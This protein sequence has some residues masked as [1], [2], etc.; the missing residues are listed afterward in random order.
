M[1][2][3]GFT[4]NDFIKHNLLVSPRPLHCMAT[5]PTCLYNTFKWWAWEE[6]NLRPLHYQ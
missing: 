1:G 4:E 6:S 2:G 3:S 5:P